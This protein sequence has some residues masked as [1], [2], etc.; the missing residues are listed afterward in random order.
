MVFKSDSGHDLARL[1]L[2]VGQVC[3]VLGTLLLAAY[4]VG[5]SYQE[6]RDEL[7]AVR[8]GQADTKQ[9]ITDE[10]KARDDQ[11]RDLSG[12]VAVVEGRLGG[13]WSAIGR[14]ECAISPRGVNCPRA[15][16]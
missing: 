8:Q 14:I 9:L 4:I 16:P 5:S 2:T 13:A 10:A 1:R 3:A 12:R 7:A 6:L 15:E 11:I